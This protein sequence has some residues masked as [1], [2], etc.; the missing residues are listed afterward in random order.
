MMGLSSN[1]YGL[2]WVA[3]KVSTRCRGEGFRSLSYE[4]LEEKR[5]LSVSPVE[6]DVFSSAEEPIALIALS[7]SELASDA[8]D[9]LLDSVEAV[10]DVLVSSTQWTERFLD[11]LDSQ[12]LG[13]GGY[14]VLQNDPSENLSWS[15]IDQIKI[16]FAEDV[17]I[18]E[19]DIFFWGVDVIDYASEI[20]FVPDSFTYDTESFTATWTLAQPIGP[21]KLKIG[22][23]QENEPVDLFAGV[24]FVELARFDVLPGDGNR[25]GK[26]DIRDVQD[27]RTRNLALA[28]A[29]ERFHYSEYF[30]FNGSGS[31]DLR[32]IQILRKNMLNTLPEGSPGNIEAMILPELFATLADDTDWSFPIDFAIEDLNLLGEIVVSS[33]QW[34]DLFLN[35]LEAQGLG[36]GGFRVDV[37]DEVILPWAN[38]NQIKLS[39]SEDVNFT[40]KDL[41]LLG[42][43]VDTL[44]SEQD[45]LSYDPESFT[46]TWNL[47]NPIASETKV[48]TVNPGENGEQTRIF[49]VLPG[50]GNQDGKVDIRD[51]QNLRKR[52]LAIAGAPERF[53]YSEYFDFNGSGSIDLRQIQILRANM[54]NT[55]EA[56]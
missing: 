45:T 7:N 10:V 56:D 41:S 18:A 44:G 8:S 32:Q 6:V 34:T 14:S 38:I 30:D 12:R 31:I 25:D 28:G 20:G 54:L 5:L 22:L 47:A 13:S 26:V 29:P 4:S 51:V 11:Y 33:T 23:L 52:N 17:E 27:L 16:V 35:Y 40:L 1:L 43:D 49:H 2:G 39:F 48:Q 3:K 46:V 55:I 42:F 53:H 24:S 36:S 37:G 15:N 19:E 9:A 50:D 21:D